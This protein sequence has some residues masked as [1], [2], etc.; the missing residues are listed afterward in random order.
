MFIENWKNWF[1]NLISRFTCYHFHRIVFHF[2]TKM[3]IFYLWFKLYPLD[4]L[5]NKKFSFY[6]SL[7]LLSPISADFIHSLILLSYL[8][9][10]FSLLLPPKKITTT[11]RRIDETQKNSLALPCDQCRQSLKYSRRHATPFFV[12]KLKQV[13][14]T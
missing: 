8:I 10:L 1:I 5:I 3:D 9:L 14:S 6:F 11:L 13:T 2:P 7:F 12:Q 4:F